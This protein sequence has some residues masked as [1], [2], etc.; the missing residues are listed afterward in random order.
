MI[1]ILFLLWE[2]RGILVCLFIYKN[3]WGVF[4][5]FTMIPTYSNDRGLFK[6]H[7]ILILNKDISFNPWYL[8]CYQQVIN[9]KLL[10]WYFNILFFFFISCLPSLV[11]IFHLQHI[12]TGTSPISSGQW[13]RMT[14]GCDTRQHILTG[15]WFWVILWVSNTKQSEN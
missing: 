9:Q 3:I 13:P 6:H 15:G 2:S 8:K 10:R 11:Y 7:I 14:D 5:S 1:L 12:S 4:C